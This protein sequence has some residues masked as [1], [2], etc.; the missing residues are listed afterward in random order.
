MT[1]GSTKIQLRV[2]LF[3]ALGLTVAALTIFAIGQQSGLF[4]RKTTLYAYFSDVN[5]LVVGAPVR[6]AGLD[7][8]TVSEIQ[9]AKSPERAE[10][11]VTMQ[12]KTRFMSRIRRDS[13]V[14]IDSKGL[15]GDK[16]LNITI[17]SAKSPAV[18]D[19]ATLA[20]RSG[21]SLEQLTGKLD[22]AIGSVTEVAQSASEAIKQLT[23]E[24]ARQDFARM[25]NSTAN[26]LQEVE[27]GDGLAHR[28][29]YD[30]KYAEQVEAILAQTQAA[31]SGVH[32]A[33]E[34][35]DRTLAAVENGNGMAHELVFGET[36]RDTMQELRDASAGLAAMM[37]QVRDGNGLVH[38]LIFEPDSGQAI[39]QLNQAATR[40]NRLMADVEKGRGTIGGLMVDPSVYEDL[41]S[42]L[43]DVKRNVLLKA[44]IRFTIKNGGIQRPAHFNEKPAPSDG[45]GSSSH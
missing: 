30:P 36:G 22:Q 14:M 29:V 2:G 28:L 10:A 11:R 33:V 40:L 34:R 24:Q 9:L 8:G 21:P 31:I 37:R 23:T 16:I 7:V 15:L 27:Q 26:I 4:E 44:L 35:M 13:T 38:N 45:A 5:G 41:K 20:T 25:L 18:E 1:R 17:G 12:I 43:G 6:L 19:G 3:L 42:I 39:E 32:S